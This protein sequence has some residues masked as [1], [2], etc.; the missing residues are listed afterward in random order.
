[1]QGSHLSLAIKEQ[2]R[3]KKIGRH[4]SYAIKNQLGCPKPPIPIFLLLACFFMSKDRWL[5]CTE[6]FFY[7][8]IYLGSYS[9]SQHRA[10]AGPLVPG[11]NQPISSTTATVSSRIGR[12]IFQDMKIFRS[13]SENIS[14]CLKIFRSLQVRKERARTVSRG[15]RPGEEESRWSAHIATLHSC[16][17]STNQYTNQSTNQVIKASEYF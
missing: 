7:R 13:C 3:S 16:I 17:K 14:W 8:C 12:K 10:T 4:Q 5:P 9:G 1:M 6:K 2:A 15:R 11:R